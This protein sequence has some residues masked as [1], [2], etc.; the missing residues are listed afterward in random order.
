[1]RVKECIAMADTLTEIRIVDR[2]ENPLTQGQWFYDNILDHI[3]DNVL[4]LNYD[5]ESNMM[6]I[7]ID[8]EV[9]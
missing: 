7:T 8:K 3:K 4:T 9:L 2:N 1:M 5:A 6:L